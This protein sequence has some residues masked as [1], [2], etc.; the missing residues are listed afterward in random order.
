MTTQELR[1]RGD[2]F[3]IKLRNEAQA[4]R[5]YAQ[6][7]HEAD[8]DGHHLYVADTSFGD[9]PNFRFDQHAWEPMYDWAA[10]YKETTDEHLAQALDFAERATW[11]NR[12]EKLDV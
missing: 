5:G 11:V 4:K 10:T 9:G 8:I 2:A 12:L 7:W 1:Q 6:L 3:L